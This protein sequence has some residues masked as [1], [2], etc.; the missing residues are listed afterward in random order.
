ML[1]YFNILSFLLLLVPILSVIDKG[2]HGRYYEHYASLGDRIV[3]EP[4]SD[5]SLVGGCVNKNKVYSKIDDIKANEEIYTLWYWGEHRFQDVR[6]DGHVLNL[7][8]IREEVDVKGF[9]QMRLCPRG[10]FQVNITQNLEYDRTI[11]FPD[12]NGILAFS[13]DINFIRS[14]YL[15]TFVPPDTVKRSIFLI[16]ACKKTLQQQY[17][18]GVGTE[19]TRNNLCKPIRRPVPDVCL[20]PW[21]G[22]NNQNSFVSTEFCTKESTPANG[23]YCRNPL[24]DP[25]REDVK[26]CETGFYCN[27]Y[28]RSS[29]PF[30]VEPIDPPAT[31][32]SNTLSPST[33]SELSSKI[34]IV[35]VIVIASV[36]IFVVA[37]VGRLVY[38]YYKYIN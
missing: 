1:Y 7:L 17:V 18:V 28:E 13:F 34:D 35:L 6:R 16:S 9:D 37:I 23:Q 36:S 29:V 2:K 8:N 3:C 25:R 22:R 26:L 30:V 33:S 24:L 14:Y 15:S 38:A 27:G 21:L 10:F 12:P 31:N 11:P 32:G 20:L 4:L 5:T 19:F